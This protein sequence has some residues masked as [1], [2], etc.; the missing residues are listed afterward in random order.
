[1]WWYLTPEVWLALVAGTIGSAPW[2][3][4]LSGWMAA[5]RPDAAWRF[6]LVSSA[7]LVAL[8]VL[9]IMSVAARTYNPFI[10]F[11]F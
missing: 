2:V 6:S 3:P 8:L 7:T 10:Y 1:V 9:S 4:A 11:R 5:R